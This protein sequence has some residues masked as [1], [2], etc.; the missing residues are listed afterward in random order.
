VTSIAMERIESLDFL[1]GIAV[2]GILIINIESFAFTLQF[3]PYL[4]GFAD[5]LDTTVRFWVYY[6]AQGKFFTMF[7]MLFGISF[8]LMLDRLQ[9]QATDSSNSHD[10][11]SIYTRR[12]LILFVIGAIHAYLIWSGDILHHYAICA[13]LLLPIRSFTKR[14]LVIFIATMVLIIYGGAYGS[15]SAR[16]EQHQAYLT[17]I[18]INEQDRNSQHNKAIDRWERKL[19]KRSK[20][21]YSSQEDAKK[22]SYLEV[23]KSNWAS[24]KLYK[25]EL[26]FKNILFDSLM[27]MA[28][29]ILL[30]RL[31]IF[32]RY[33]NMPYYWPITVLLFL[34]GLW[35]GYIKYYAWSFDY[36]KPVT[37]VDIEFIKKM[38]AYIQGISYLLLING[39]Y[40][41]VAVI[42]KLTVVNQVGKM[43]LSSYIF[44]SIVCALIFYGYGLNYHNQLSRSELLWLIPAIWLA[45]IVLCRIWLK[46]FTQGPLES[47]WRKLSLMAVKV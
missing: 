29:G 7:V 36:L 26:F 4:Y 13:L 19:E 34:T 15:A 47:I 40:Q 24:I 28:V 32:S 2:L 20:E 23:V 46:Y 1:R 17:A 5:E 27:L 10:V 35:M 30:Y 25:G 38:A 9:Q 22:G 39:I 12:I 16:S 8:Y 21:R 43:A 44:H 42:K 11:Y 31:G 45:N 18:Q 41:S 3:N 33:Q 6:L 14:G 37:E